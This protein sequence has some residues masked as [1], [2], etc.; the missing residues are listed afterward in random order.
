MAD[1]LDT[2]HTRQVTGSTGAVLDTGALFL[3][4]A[5][6]FA[7]TDR[8]TLDGSGTETFTSR[9]R[10]DRVDL[11][12]EWR[13]FGPLLLHFGAENEWISYRTLFDPGEDTRSTGAYAQLGIEYD[14]LSGHIGMRVD[15]HADFGTAVTLGADVSYEVAPDWRLRAS[16]GEGFKAPTLFQLHS[17]YGNLL[18]RPEQ[19]TSFDFGLAYGDRSMARSDAYG[20][21]TLYQRN[22]DNQIA[23]V[24]CFAQTNGI[25]ANRPFGTYDNITRT[26]ARGME[27][28][29]W[30]RPAQS[31]TLGAVYTFTDAENRDTGLDL[32]RRPRRAATLTGEWRPVES[33]VLG[34][35]LRVV[36][37]SFDD[38]FNTVRLD[39]YEIL[40]LRGSWD[41]NEHVQLFAR[42]ENVWDEQYQTAAGYATP[43]ASAH[44]GARVAL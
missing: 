11:R 5:Y 34:A 32:A 26:R 14:A 6:S 38:A 23:Y 4:A 9:G 2:Q 20:A 18:L 17:D 7:D 8:D 13:F 39:G 27:V 40:T 3:S 24:S 31:V 28:E 42:I 33:V 22:T 36:S 1:T 41:V 43:G 10:S 44:L 30:A 37:S 12:G 16:L 15:D 19:S 29:L 21:V 35:D 25:C